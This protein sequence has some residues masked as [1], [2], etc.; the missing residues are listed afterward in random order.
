MRCYQ[1]LKLLFFQV[2]RCGDTWE[3]TPPFPVNT[4]KRIVR[5]GIYMPPWRTPTVMI[6]NLHPKMS[7]TSARDFVTQLQLHV[8]QMQY[9][10]KHGAT[11]L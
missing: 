2:G 6:I 4:S 10:V 7:L 9:H 3:A 8:P 5:L 11:V 1:G